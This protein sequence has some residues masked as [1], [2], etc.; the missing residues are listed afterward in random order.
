MGPRSRRELLLRRALAWSVGCLL[1]GAFYLLLI[2]TTDLPEL[3]VGIGVAVLAATGVELAREQ[4]LVG[5][6]A[7]LRWLARAYR[8]VAKVP[9]D[10]TIVSLAAVRQIV[11]REVTCGEFRAVRFRTGEA[12]DS[13]ETGRRAL[14]EALGSLAP[15]TIVIGIDRERELILAHQL[16]RTGGREAIDLLEL[17]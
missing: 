5:E 6:N 4:Q 17:G 15:N 12:D 3:L 2:D 1:A 9:L 16:H 10:V 8:P 11:R 7:R 14:A 13:L